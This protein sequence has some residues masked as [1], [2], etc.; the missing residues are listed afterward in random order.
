ME[1]LIK[2]LKCNIYCLKRNKVY[3][4]YVLIVF[5]LLAFFDQKNNIYLIDFDLSQFTDRGKPHQ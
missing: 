1:E 3:Y 4:I 2:N 5:F